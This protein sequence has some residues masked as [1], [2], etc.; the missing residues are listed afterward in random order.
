MTQHI[1]EDVLPNEIEQA[2][3]TAVAPLSPQNAD[4]L[5]ARVLDKIKE[6][7]ENEPAP[8][9]TIHASEGPWIAIAPLV[10]IKVLRQEGQ[11]ASFLLRVQPGG[12]LP[13]HVHLEDEECLVLQGSLL[14]GEGVMLRAGDYHRAA[15]GS[16]H[17]PA[18][19]NTGVLLFLRS[20][21]PAYQP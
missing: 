2:L 13:D 3:L 16:P 7:G 21:N 9:L 8:Y 6:Q 15:K 10:E 4:K 1:T 5:S 14:L 18:S 11:S 19:T 20:D 12:Q 17:G